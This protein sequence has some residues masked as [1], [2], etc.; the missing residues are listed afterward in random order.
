MLNQGRQSYNSRGRRC[1]QDHRYDH[2]CDRVYSR[3]EDRIKQHQDSY[4]RWGHAVMDRRPEG[5]TM[6]SQD[7]HG[8]QSDSVTDRIGPGTAM[9]VLFEGEGM[10]MTV[11]TIETTEGNQDNHSTPEPTKAAGNQ[12][13]STERCTDGEWRTRAR[14]T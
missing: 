6:Q 13:C 4:G 12:W 11:A 2:H 9:P 3:S 5:R 7:T 1:S 10:P 8:K 14:K